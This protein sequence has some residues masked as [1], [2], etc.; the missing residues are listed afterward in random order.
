MGMRQPAR[1]SFRPAYGL[2]GVDTAS[3]E[4][5]RGAPSGAIP[6][7]ILVVLLAVATVWFV[8]R[9]MLE[10]RSEPQR[11]CEVIVLASGTTKCVHEP[12]RASRAAHAKSTTRAKH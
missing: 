6:L 7:L 12:A 2:P 5:A 10:S 3:D 11:T 4:S 8:A 9:P 1:P